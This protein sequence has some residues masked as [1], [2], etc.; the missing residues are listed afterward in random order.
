MKLIA[1]FI[2]TIM[3]IPRVAFIESLI[4]AL[5]IRCKNIKLKKESFNHGREKN[6]II[7]CEKEF[8]KS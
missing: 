2:P 5:Q 3:Q 6:P 4:N 8:P 1:I 7:V